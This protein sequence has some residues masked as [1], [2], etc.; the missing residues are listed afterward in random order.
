MSN[1]QVRPH[2]HFYPE[3]SG[4]HLAEA[5]QARRW[6]HDL[7]PELTTPTILHRGKI[8]YTFEPTL[9]TG[10]RIAIPVRW[11]MRNNQ[12]HAQC[13]RLVQV[14]G[15]GGSFLRVIKTSGFEISAHELLKPF[16]ELEAAIISRPHAYPFDSVS[17]IRG[18]SGL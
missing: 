8:Y 6:L 7:P 12:M 16:P 15:E 17:T 5:R 3:D 14:Y 10:N 2:L 11:F 18:T 1:P 4:S 9:M 13:W